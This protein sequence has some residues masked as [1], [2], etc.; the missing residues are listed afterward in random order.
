MKKLLMALSMALTLG[1]TAQAQTNVEV[2]GKM[3]MYQDHDK[4][5]TASSVSKVTNDLSRIG[6]RGTENLGGGLKAEF[7]IETGVAA[8]APSASTLGDYQSTVGISNS[9]V[10]V[11]L[12]RQKHAVAN[13]LTKYDPFGT[14]Y[15]STAYTI[16]NNQS[17]RTSN[18]A[19]VV[20]TPVNGLIMS[21]GH[22]YSEVAGTPGVQNYGADYTY[23]PASVGVAVYDNQAGTKTVIGGARYTL[24]TKTVVSVMHSEDTVSNVTTKGT[25]IGAVQ[26]L[27]ANLS[28]LVA[29]GHKSTVDAYNAGLQ[30]AFSKRTLGH[31]R[32]RVEKADLAS[33]D[34]KQ[35]G[36]GLEHNF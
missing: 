33:A 3:R 27:T 8:D 32:Y 5:G 13:L 4:V 23:G 6:F 24:P 29:Y 34:R 35:F 1:A 10:G 26:P 31:V 9:L 14:S 20:V 18:G 19:T 12:G 28:A 22:S 25:T 7:V 11:Q 36:I 16:H 17:L 2:Y 30:Y 21:Y 15:A